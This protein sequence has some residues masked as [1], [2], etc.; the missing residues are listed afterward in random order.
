MKIID[1]KLRS[2]EN[3]EKECNFFCKVRQ[4]AVRSGIIE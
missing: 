1:K 2:T 3:R 4:E